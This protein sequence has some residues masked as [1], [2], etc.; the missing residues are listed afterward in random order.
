[1]ARS[2][3]SLWLAASAAFTAVAVALLGVNATFDAGR[4]HYTF[5]TSGLMVIVY[6]TGV[7][8]II[9]FAGAMRQWTVP[10]S[11]DRPHR[12]APADPVEAPGQLAGVSDDLDGG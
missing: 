4:P 7:L 3:E 9:C 8:A 1:V 6:V 12:G 2:H 10:L 11:G 5:W